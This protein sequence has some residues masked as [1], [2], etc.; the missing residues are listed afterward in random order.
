MGPG[1]RYRYLNCGTG[2]ERLRWWFGASLVELWLWRL[3]GWAL[4][5]LEA[6]VDVANVTCATSKG[7]S[8]CAEFVQMQRSLQFAMFTRHQTLASHDYAA[9]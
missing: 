4:F 6:E 3:S 5:S 2:A 7:R 1:V 9:T 8:N